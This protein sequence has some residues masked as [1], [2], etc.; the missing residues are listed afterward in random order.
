MGEPR[1]PIRGANASALPGTGFNLAFLP[2]PPSCA[3]PGMIAALPAAAD[4]EHKMSGQI[5]NLRLIT[6]AF[7]ITYSTSPSP[8][9]ATTLTT[10][11]PGN[12]CCSCRCSTGST[13]PSM[14]SAT[15]CS[16]LSAHNVSSIS[17]SV[18]K[19]TT[20]SAFYLLLTRP[21]RS[22]SR[23]A[24]STPNTM[25]EQVQNL[26]H[27]ALNAVHFSCHS[28]GSPFLLLHCHPLP[29]HEHI[30]NQTPGTLLLLQP[31]TTQN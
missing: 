21:L 6:H 18:T 1:F 9:S 5:Q 13:L 27:S 12:C 14:S 8:S 19:C 30:P 25:Q 11:C 29:H 16:N 2:R 4:C 7:F 17:Q 24:C 28:L 26:S 22:L 10:T 3:A 31:A 15:A 23:P 20:P